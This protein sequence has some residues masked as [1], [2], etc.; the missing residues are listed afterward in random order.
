MSH[1]KVIRYMYHD[2]KEPG[3]LWSKER[4]GAYSLG[5]KGWTQFMECGGNKKNSLVQSCLCIF[6][7]SSFPLFMDFW[8]NVCCLPIPASSDIYTLRLPLSPHLFYKFLNYQTKFRAC[9]CSHQ[10]ML[11]LDL[12][13]HCSFS[14]KRIEM[15]GWCDCLLHSSSV[16]PE[17]SAIFFVFIAWPSSSDPC[18]EKDP[19]SLVVVELKLYQGE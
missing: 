14:P 5:L 3:K 12:Y 17:A 10:G 2:V 8:V 18:A 9:S 11:M 19:G 4:I 15:I 1:T 16:S 6:F 13:I 7:S